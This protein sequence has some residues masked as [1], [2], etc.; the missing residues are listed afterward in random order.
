MRQQLQTPKKCIYSNNTSDSVSVTQST[1]SNTLDQDSDWTIPQ[2]SISRSMPSSPLM[3]TIPHITISPTILSNQ[4]SCLSFLPDR[5]RL[6][7]ETRHLPENDEVDYGFR[8]L[9]RYCNSSL[10]KNAAYCLQNSYF[11]SYTSL[12]KLHIAKCT[13]NHK[14]GQRCGSTANEALPHARFPLL[15]YKYVTKAMFVLFRG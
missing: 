7:E 8:L 3:G 10:G 6:L 12:F 13:F 9:E 5:L 4:E 14:T 15:S 2:H 1:V 11:I